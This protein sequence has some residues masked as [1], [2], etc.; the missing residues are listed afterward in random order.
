LLTCNWLVLDDD[1]YISGFNFGHERRKLDVVTH[2][3]RLGF[4]VLAVGDSY[5]D[6]EMLDAADAGFLFRPS[7]QLATSRSDLHTVWDFAELET[8]LRKASSRDL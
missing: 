2:F 6:L 1:G 3:Q 7:A 4:R 5:N 8:E